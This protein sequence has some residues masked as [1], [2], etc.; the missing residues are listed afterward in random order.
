MAGTALF[1]NGEVQNSISALAE[2]MPD[3]ASA[4]ESVLQKCSQQTVVFPHNLKFR[5]ERGMVMS[6]VVGATIDFNG[7][8]F[9][10]PADTDATEL[11]ITLCSHCTI[12]NLK[13]DGNRANNI[14]RDDYGLHLHKSQGITVDH[15]L[16]KDITHHGFWVDIGTS[17]AR[18]YDCALQDIWDFASAA[19]IYVANAE[20]DDVE[21]YRTTVN[22]SQYVSNQA[23]YLHG[24]GNVTVDGVK[25]T[26]IA[27]YV[28]DVRLGKN[29]V[30]NIVADRCGGLLISQAYPGETPGTVEA[31]GMAGAHME[32]RPG[33]QA[34][35]YLLDTAGAAI[36]NIET[37]GLIGSNQYGVRIRNNP[38]ATVR[39]VSF[40]NIRFDGYKS[41]GIYLHNLDESVHFENVKLNP[42]NSGPLVVCAA[43]VTVPQFIQNLS[44]D[45]PNSGNVDPN[46]RLVVT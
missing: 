3:P 37:S 27:G 31:D 34:E 28:I 22:R 1:T 42:V 39:H 43:D 33:V 23:F 36:R 38:A 18:F 44:S 15:V 32:G 9:I 12:R 17:G 24:A 13:L 41:A 20:S 46:S 26:N 10:L 21:F 5:L 2:E 8:E 7:C 45:V 35:I 16:V 30:K 40:Q 25:A 4:I 29:V 19:E 6:G 14:G 11:L